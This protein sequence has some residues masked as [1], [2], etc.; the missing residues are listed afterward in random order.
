MVANY[1]ELTLSVGCFS[2][3]MQGFDDLLKQDSNPVMLMLHRRLEDMQVDIYAKLLDRSNGQDSL[4]SDIYANR[5]I[6]IPHLSIADIRIIY[7]IA[8][9]II[10]NRKSALKQNDDDDELVNLSYERDM[11]Q[12]LARALNKVLQGQKMPL[13]EMQ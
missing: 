8:S 1:H 9:A 5:K 4:Y 10:D 11:F 2:L 3:L 6:N 13:L 12:E 7:H